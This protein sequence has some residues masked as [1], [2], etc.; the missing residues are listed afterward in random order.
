MSQIL[1]AV[2]GRCGSGGWRGVA[3]LLAL[4]AA[5]PAGAQAVTE[6]S[7]LE[8]LPVVLSASRMPQSL[9]ATPGAVTVLDRDFIRA[10][11]YRDIPSLLKLVP[12][13]HAVS[14]RGGQTHVT[15]HGFG[16]A[17]P[18]RMQ[19]L[20]DGRSVYSPS[21]Y[22]GVDWF[23]VP[24]TI[25]EIERIEVLR[26]S[27]SA[28]YGSNAFMGVVNIVTQQAGDRPGSEIVAAAGS[29]KLRDFSARHEIRSGDLGLRLNAEVRYDHGHEALVDSPRHGIA[30]LRADYQLGHRDELSFWAGVNDSRRGFGYAGDPVNT[31]GL[32]AHRAQYSFVHLRWRRTLS[33]AEEIQAGYYRNEERAREESQVYLPPFFPVVPVDFNRTSVRDNFDF[34]HL[35]APSARTRVAWGIEVRRDRIESRRFFHA[36]GAER[37]ELARLFGNLEWRPHAKLTLNGGAMLERYAGR[38]AKLAPRL[39]A[40]WHLLPG[41][42]LRAGSTVAY[43]APSLF[44][45]KADM[46]FYSDG[47]TGTLL[48]TSWIG[49]REIRPE[50]VHANEL[51][52]VGQFKAWDAVLDLRIFREKVTDFALDVAVPPP[53]GVVFPSSNSFSNSDLPVRF[54][55]FEW[56]YRAR[57]AQGAQ[58]MFGH[59]SVSAR[60][61]INGGALA[62]QN[63]RH[64]TTLTWLQEWSS[65]WSSALSA[66]RY[67]GYHYGSGSLPMPGYTSLDA[68]LAYRF[69]TAAR[70]AE[71]ALV[72]LNQ[73]KRHEEYL[74]NDNAAAG[75]PVPRLAFVTLRFGL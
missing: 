68:R 67:G 8:E 4:A 22:G 47:Y 11:G 28:T 1:A 13:F 17:Y 34:Q 29:D 56:H 52:Y 21:F 50:R 31:N 64:T 2:R 73:G 58:L 59:A 35:F 49:A 62:R 33:A 10:T 69:G 20:I 40:N 54:R 43:R 15:Y 74:F 25:D 57:P 63:P 65:R 12:G 45:E 26:G 44:E 24:V 66:I 23:L 75:N 72:L 42:T 38:E 16:N 70:P 37:Q 32:R 55:G 71:I 5:A 19:V 60:S 41:H 18:N 48:Q 36:S 39:F 6:K 9:A 61:D 14:E 30:T 53:A 7:F 46:R 51:G 3:G 27:N